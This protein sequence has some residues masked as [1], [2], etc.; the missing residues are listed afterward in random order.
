[1]SLSFKHCIN[2]FSTKS[3]SK[4]FS[5]TNL[6]ECEVRSIPNGKDLSPILVTELGITI[7]CKDS[8]PPKA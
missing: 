8:Q 6:L 5:T 2:L 7:L 3:I 4:S 1:M